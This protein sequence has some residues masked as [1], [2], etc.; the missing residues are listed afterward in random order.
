MTNFLLDGLIYDEF[1][2]M[3]QKESTAPF[4]GDL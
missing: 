4:A 3:I 1:F 2:P